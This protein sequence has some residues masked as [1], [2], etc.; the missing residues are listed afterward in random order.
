M[1]FNLKILES[2]QKCD[3]SDLFCLEILSR[4][5]AY[6]QSHSEDTL[7]VRLKKTPRVSNFLKKVSKLA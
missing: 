1:V 2:E 4:L 3:L 7:G 6:R 5:L